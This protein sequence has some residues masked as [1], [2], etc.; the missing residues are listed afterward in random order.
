MNTQFIELKFL[1]R[2]DTTNDP[3]NRGKQ[4][5]EFIEK[6]LLNVL[7]FLRCVRCLFVQSLNDLQQEEKMTYLLKWFAIESIN[8]DV[9]YIN[10]LVKS[11]AVF[12]SLKEFFTEHEIEF[13][14]KLRIT[15]TSDILLT[16]HTAMKITIEIDPK[17]ET[18]NENFCHIS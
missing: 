14:Q 13:L 7:E 12:D 17:F 2:I 18:Y 3:Q 10:L 9:F 11:G 5:K 16:E 8:D 15:V 6:N 1:D 4:L